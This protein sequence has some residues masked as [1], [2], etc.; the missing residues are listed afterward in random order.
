MA[1]GKRSKKKPK[2]RSSR[3]FPWKLWSS[4]FVFGYLL[5]AI[6]VLS[7]PQP[8]KITTRSRWDTNKTRREFAAWGK[9]LSFLGLEASADEMDAFLW[10]LAQGTG[11]VVRILRAPFKPFMRVTG[12]FQSWR[13]F[14]TPNTSTVAWVVVELDRGDGAFEPIYESR[15]STYDWR[16][17]QLSH[18]RMRKFISKAVRGYETADFV[19]LGRWFAQEAAHDFPEAEAVRVVARYAKLEGPEAWMAGAPLEVEDRKAKVFKLEKFRP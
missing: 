11:K 7:L 12:F 14:S 1:A 17:F 15:S 3:A 13:M 9:S 19:R 2:K 16:S 6:F 18:D 10:P 4:R 5:A 8:H